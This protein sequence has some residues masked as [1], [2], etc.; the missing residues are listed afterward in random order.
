ME[1]GDL[2]LIA[3]VVLLPAAL[4]WA[5]FIA[6]SG[7]PGKPR[8]PKLGIPPALRPADPDEVLEGP[9]LER[10]LIWMLVS[11]LVTAIFI[12]A[13]W[14]PERERQAHFQERYDEDAE[15]R[16]AFVY[17]VPATLDEDVEASEFKE[18]EEGIALGQGCAF[19]HGGDGGGGPVPTG[20]VNPATDEQVQYEAPP[21]NNVLTRWDD[22]VVRFTIERGRPGT[23]MP[24]WGIE[25]GGP[26]NEQAVT[27][28]MAYLKTFEG[29]QEPI[30]LPEACGD[31]AAN[32]DECSTG[33]EIFEARC[34]VCHGDRGQGKDDDTKWYPGMALWGGDVTHLDED[35]HFI[36]VVNGRRFAFMPQFGESPSQ[37]IPI[38]PNPLTDDQIR[39]VVEY[40]RG[41]PGPSGD[42]ENEDIEEDLEAEQ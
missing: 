17:A 26:M 40:E 30:E 9:R 18:I 11:I 29:N 13:Y 31:G 12:P 20:F 38:P 14:L 22:E 6:R 8:R 25:Y 41:L 33:Q 37:G 24:A 5:V 16:G 34:A 7:R 3:L 2:L 4:L 39:A 19:C 32:T 28:V 1:S 21:L 10:I 36:T 35:Q 23:P 27:D 15:H 42:G